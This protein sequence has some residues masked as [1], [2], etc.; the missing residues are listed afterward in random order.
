MS[1]YGTYIETMD[2]IEDR[3]VNDNNYP[4]IR[5][6]KIKRCC[7]ISLEFLKIIFEYL[8]SNT[9]ATK[10][11]KQRQLKP[12]NLY[13]KTLN[14]QMMNPLLSILMRNKN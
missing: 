10:E 14:C 7:A 6:N 11:S 4:I 9:N 1:E 12:N 2:D 8:K 3:I 5:D 13:L